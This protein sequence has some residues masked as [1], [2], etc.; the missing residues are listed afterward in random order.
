MITP[1]TKHAESSRPNRSRAACDERLVAV[2]AGEVDVGHG[3]DRCTERFEFGD[4][5]VERLLDADHAAVAGGALQ[6]EVVAAV[7]H[8]AGERRA[9][10]SRW[11]S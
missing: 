9:R 7:G 11:P 1:V 4:L 8:R 6:H 10:R 2:G 5:V 3:F